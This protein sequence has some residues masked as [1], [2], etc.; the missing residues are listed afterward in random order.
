MPGGCGSLGRAGL[1][2]TV[3]LVVVWVRAAAARRPSVLGG[4]GTDG[5]GPSMR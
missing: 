3:V 5:S 4:S 2:P 1:A